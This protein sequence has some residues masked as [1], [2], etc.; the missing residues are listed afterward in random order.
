MCPYLR[1]LLDELLALCA[2]FVTALHVSIRRQT[3]RW[4]SK[5][6]HIR[7]RRP[8]QVATFQS[9]DNPRRVEVGVE[10]NVIP[11]SSP[12]VSFGK[13]HQLLPKASRVDF[14]PKRNQSK[15]NFL[16]QDQTRRAQVFTRHP[17]M[18]QAN[19][20][21]LPAVLRSVWI[22]THGHVTN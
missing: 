13:R 6:D 16:H 5:A 4:T 7:F 11:K 19:L 9:E 20:A 3:D 22:R 1:V 12:H 8:N 10:W 2:C 15:V 18:Q 17:E 21:C 14:V